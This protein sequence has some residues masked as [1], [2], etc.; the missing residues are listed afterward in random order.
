MH[1]CLKGDGRLGTQHVLHSIVDRNVSWMGDL[2]QLYRQHT[3][4]KQYGCRKAKTQTQPTSAMHARIFIGKHTDNHAN[5]QADTWGSILRA[6]EESQLLRFWD[7][8]GHISSRI[9]NCTK[10]GNRPIYNAATAHFTLHSAHFDFTIAQI[11]INYTLKYALLWGL[12]L[13]MQEKWLYPVMYRNMKWEHFHKVVTFH[14]ERLCF[15]WM[16]IPG[17]IPQFP[18]S[19]DTRLLPSVELTCI[20]PTSPQCS[21]K[22]DAFGQTER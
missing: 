18:K 2:I 19:C 22:I 4:E 8:A 3:T 12:Q 17:I 15:Y 1:H 10:P 11:V 21:K 14:K 5:K 9:Y 6:W 7:G 13:S 20:G 16:R